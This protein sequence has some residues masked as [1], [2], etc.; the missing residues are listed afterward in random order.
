MVQASLMFGNDLNGVGA[1]AII[2]SIK[3]V[4]PSFCFFYLFSSAGLRPI[5]RTMTSVET[6]GPIDVGF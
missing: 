6:P 1:I 2:N 3:G 5:S 4:D